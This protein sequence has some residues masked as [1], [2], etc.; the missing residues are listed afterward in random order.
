MP[1]AWELLVAAALLTGTFF[2][3]VSCI[4]LFRLPDVFCRMHAAGKAG[5]LGVCLVVMAA[6]LH[7]ATTDASVVWRGVLAIWFQ[8]LTT[9]AATHLLARAS[10]LADYPR[11]DRTAVDEL[12]AFLPSRPG[13]A[14]GHE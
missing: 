3:V 1:S 13:G 2:T 6:M 5:T 4:G 10:Y 8:L 9:P 14:S 12:R 7:F 11:T